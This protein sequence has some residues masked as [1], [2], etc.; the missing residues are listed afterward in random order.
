MFEYIDNIL[1]VAANWLYSEEV[2]ILTYP[3]YKALVNRERINR[4]RRGGG[5]DTI[6]WVEYKS[7]PQRF[8]RPIEEFLGGKPEELFKESKPNSLTKYLQEDLAAKDF[9]ELFIKTNGQPL[10]QKSKEKYQAD[11]IIFNAITELIKY[12]S[13]F[14]RGQKSN[15]TDFW[16]NVT[17]AIHELDRGTYPHSIKNNHR[18]VKRKYDKYIEHSYQGLIHGSEG[19]NNPEKI[20]GEILDW[21]IAIHSMPM[22]FS[23]PQ[24]MVRYNSIREEKGWPSLTHQAVNKRLHEPEIERKWYLGRHGEDA[25]MAK[26][27]HF[28]KRKRDN[29]FPNAYWVIDGSKLDWVHYYDNDQK[30]AAHLKIDVVIDVY[31]EKIIGYSFSETED[32]TDHFTAVKM[33]V[34]NSGVHPYLFTYDGQSGHTSSMMQSLYDR[35][36]AHPKGDHYKHKARRKGNPIEQIFSRLQRQVLN[37]MWNSDKQSIKSRDIDAKLNKEFILEYKHLLKPKQDLLKA[38]KAM[39]NIWNSA[40]HPHFD[41]SRNEVFQHEMPM[42]QEISFIDQVEMFWIQAR[43]PSTYGRGGLELEVKG[44]TYWFE[45]LDSDNRIDI[46]FRRKYVG[47]KFVVKYDPEYLSEFIRLYLPDSDGNLDFI[48]NAQ[49][50]RAHEVIPALKEEGDDARFRRDYQVREIEMSLDEADMI[51]ARKRAGITPEVII[52][53]QELL[54]KMGGSLPKKERTVLESSFINGL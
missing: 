51:A 29:W 36:V 25:Y 16:I 34:N 2:Q 17:A 7:L 46:S 33:S 8:K 26:Y 24:E 21:W 19:N 41:S 53:E 6:A 32:H 18:A 52:E 31:S 14:K 42:R 38:F 12:R 39:V 22:K 10:S 28:I 9:F 23:V 37:I 13:K 54:M 20:T 44:T 30:M 11:A 45:V 49:T 43:R 1:C 50:K 27:S 35:L 4:V 48:A 5:S 15:S 3:N 47:K 40:K